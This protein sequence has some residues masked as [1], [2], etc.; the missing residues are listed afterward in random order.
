MPGLNA[1]GCVSEPD[2]HGAS[3]AGYF[4]CATTDGTAQLVLLNSSHIGV[5]LV[6]E[7]LLETSVYSASF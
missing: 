7:Q 4:L 1:H 6:F 2:W 3:G 5:P